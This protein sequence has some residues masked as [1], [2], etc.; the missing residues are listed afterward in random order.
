MVRRAEHP[1]LHPL[2]Q[3]PLAARRLLEADDEVVVLRVPRR[4]RVA[5]RG[6][7]P[8]V[9]A[10]G[11]RADR[12][13]VAARKHA[14]VGVVPHLVRRDHPLDREEHALP[15]G[16]PAPE[17][18]CVGAGAQGVA[19]RVRG[20]GVVDGQVR[21]QGPQHPVGTR[22]E[23]IVH[24]GP[25]VLVVRGDPRA[26]GPLGRQERHA[27]RGRLQPEGEAEQRPVLDLQ[28]PGAQRP[29]HH[30]ARPRRREDVAA[31]GG[32]HPVHQPQ[33]DQGQGV[34]DRALGD[35]L[36]VGLGPGE[37]PGQLEA[38]R[39]RHGV[40]HA[41]VQA[42]PGAD[43]VT[44][45]LRQRPDLAR[46]SLRHLRHPQKERVRTGRPSAVSTTIRP[47]LESTA[48]RSPSGPIRTSVSCSGTPGAEGSG[49]RVAR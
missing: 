1:A 2:L 11:G 20:P 15:G 10:E 33:V 5:V 12:T 35:D 24:L 17:P 22:A 16:H 6:Q 13:H 39:V 28:A 26:R 30:R 29:L 25:G 45:G 27:Q 34:E 4:A 18:F 44:H 46:G 9:R 40:D 21:R 37:R 41:Q 38:G 43:E 14:Q 3:G 49:V 36:E 47:P 23:R 7:P 31:V 19:L 48:Y 8:G 32:D 42:H